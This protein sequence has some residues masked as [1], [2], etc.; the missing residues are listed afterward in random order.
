[1]HFTTST[2]LLAAFACLTL[3]SPIQKEDG[4]HTNIGDPFKDITYDPVVPAKGNIKDDPIKDISDNLIPIQD[5]TANATK[6][7]EARG[8]IFDL[9][10]RGLPPLNL[11]NSIVMDG[12]WNLAVAGGGLG[13]NWVT[14][15]G[16]DDDL[17]YNAYTDRSAGIA[18]AHFNFRVRAAAYFPARQSVRWTV[19][20][21]RSGTRTCVASGTITAAN[22]S[23]SASWPLDSTAS[24]SLTI[25]DAY[26]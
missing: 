5:E 16:N 20:E 15:P 21:I 2:T 24:Y 17:E 1:M 4:S 7:L 19:T 13:G 25:Q 18:Y 10:F 11:E 26:E 3:A 12:Y 22:D 9:C 23:E 14:A 6:Q 8:S